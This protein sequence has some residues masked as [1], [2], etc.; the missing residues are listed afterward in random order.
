MIMHGLGRLG[1][2]VSV[3]RLNHVSDT[4]GY[5]CSFEV[6]VFSC[7]LVQHV[8]LKSAT[9]VQLVHTPYTR[10]KSSKLSPVA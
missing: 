9:A 5:I 4:A 1:V 6:L 10:R 3:L 2:R 8:R 7:P